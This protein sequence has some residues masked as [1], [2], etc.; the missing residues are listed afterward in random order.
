MKIQTIL[1]EDVAP[2]TAPSISFN[3][4]NT[5]QVRTLTRIAN[6]EVDV[7][8]ADEKEYDIMSDLVEL[9]L[10]DAEYQLAQRGMNAVALAKKLGG[11]AEVLAA[12]QRTQAM[13]SQSGAN[14]DDMVDEPDGGPVADGGAIR[15]A[16]FDDFEDDETGDEFD[17][18]LGR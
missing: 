16:P 13:K 11:S 14:D 5:L 7:D 10:L 4:L 1:N 9:G 17:F 3:D 2:A 8:S 6:G 12:R 18:K 15:Q